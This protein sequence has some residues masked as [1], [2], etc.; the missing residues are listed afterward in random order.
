MRQ[1]DTGANQHCI[2][3]RAQI[4]AFAV[5]LRALCPL[6]KAAN[7]HRSSFDFSDGTTTLIS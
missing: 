1:T 6:A 5:M 2:I 4:E 7:R 3:V